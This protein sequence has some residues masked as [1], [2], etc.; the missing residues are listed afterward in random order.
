MKK[1][2]FSLTP[3]EQ[4]E[5]EVVGGCSDVTHLPLVEEDGHV[6]EV[7]VVVPQVAVNQRF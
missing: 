4:K 2:F 3:G 1:Y 7:D 6:V 5:T